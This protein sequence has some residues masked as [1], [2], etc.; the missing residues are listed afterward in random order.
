MILIHTSVKLVTHGQ[1]PHI[2]RDDILIHTSV[3]LVTSRS[4]PD[5]S[6]KAILIHTSVKLVT[7]TQRTAALQTVILIHTSVKL[8]TLLLVYAPPVK[9][10]F[11]PHEREARDVLL[12]KEVRKHGHFNPHER[13]A[14]DVSPSLFRNCRVI[15]LIHTSVKLVT[16]S[17]PITP[18]ALTILIHTSVKLVT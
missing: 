7:C 6:P 11:N 4:A 1:H 10:Y 16:D 8:V 13:E 12:E 5:Q 15:I 3:K 2:R 18:S 14:R 9:P 17:P